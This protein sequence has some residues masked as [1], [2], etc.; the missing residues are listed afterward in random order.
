M[1]EAARAHISDPTAIFTDAAQ[2]DQAADYSFASGIFNVRFEEPVER[3]R[4][5]VLATLRNMHEFSRCGFAFNLLTSYVDWKEDHL[6]YADPCFFFDFCKREFSR[7]VSL[8]HDTSL[9][10]WTMIVRR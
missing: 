4:D 2:L 8:L 6:Y 3:W 7:K 1:L 10:E 5:Y 9:W